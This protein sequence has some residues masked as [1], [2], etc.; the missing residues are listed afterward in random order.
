MGMGRLRVEL[1]WVGHLRLTWVGQL[2]Q[3]EL[4]FFGRYE[5]VLVLRGVPLPVIA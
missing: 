4:L 1:K 3:S 5:K 2:W